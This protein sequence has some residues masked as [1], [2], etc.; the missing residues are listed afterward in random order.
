M[1]VADCRL[2]FT[3]RQIMVKAQVVFLKRLL[4]VKSRMFWRVV[5]TVAVELPKLRPLSSSLIC[6]GGWQTVNWRITATN[7]HGV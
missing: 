3:L 7:W 6:S 2:G 1:F 4:I 5:L